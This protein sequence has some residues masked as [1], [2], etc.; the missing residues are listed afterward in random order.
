MYSS[1]EEELITTKPSQVWNTLSELTTQ[2][3]IIGLLV[4]LVVLSFL[5]QCEKDLGPVMSLNTFH[6]L[7]FNSQQFQANLQNILVFYEIHKY[8]VLYMGIKSECPSNVYKC[9]SSTS[10]NL[11]YTQILPTSNIKKQEIREKYREA[12][13]LVAISDDE[14]SEAYF[15]VKK[16]SIKHF[17]MNVSNFFGKYTLK[18]T[19]FDLSF[20]KHQFFANGHCFLC[21][22]CF[23][24]QL[25]HHIDLQT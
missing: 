9:A 15:S 25:R 3:L 18:H 8:V 19:H 6:G 10:N 5:T 12:E 23:L 22:S 21:F 1:E 13:I 20:H 17:M 7:E 2:K 4:L 16:S 24:N 11:T 14:R